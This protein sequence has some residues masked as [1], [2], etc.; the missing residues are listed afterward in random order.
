MP[1]NPNPEIPTTIGMRIDSIIA[2]F[3]S[4]PHTYQ[5]FVIICCVFAFWV[6]NS[7]PNPNSNATTAMTM[8]KKQNKDNTTSTSTTTT[9]KNKKNEP[10]PKWHILKILNILSVIGLLFSF[11][12]FAC[13]TSSYLNGGDTHA[14]MKIVG[15]WSAF[16]CYFFGFFGISFIDA[17]DLEC[18]TTTG[19]N[20]NGNAKSVSKSGDKKKSKKRYVHI[21]FETFESIFNPSS[22]LLFCFRTIH[23]LILMPLFLLLLF[24]LFWL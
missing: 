23:F 12:W 7:N 5:A 13:N 19:N 15:I 8:I 22:S 14:L 18:E 11:G 20:G 21:T 10:Q 9:S 1:N 17:E 4:I 16:L 2:K 3:D 6:L 24:L